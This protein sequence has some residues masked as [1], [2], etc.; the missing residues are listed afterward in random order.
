VLVVDDESAARTFVERVLR[1]AG[2]A[3]DTA[4]SGLESLSIVEHEGTFDL[5]VIDVVMPGMLGD[6]LARRM[7]QRHPDAKVLYFTGDPERLLEMYVL[8]RNDVLL[9]K[10]TSVAALRETVSLLLFDH[11]H[12]P[13]WHHDVPRGPQE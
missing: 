11:T 9:A 5:F 13:K 1:D 12:G 10:P 6:E 7:R 3:V 4:A 2:Y 8:G